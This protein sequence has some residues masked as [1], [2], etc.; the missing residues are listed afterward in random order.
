MSVP[1]RQRR[2]RPSLVVRVVQAI[3][4]VV[5]VGGPTAMIVGG[6]VGVA[7]SR[8]IDSSGVNTTAAVVDN[9]LHCNY[10]DVTY[11]T[12]VGTQEHGMVDTDGC[13]AV[14]SQVQVSYDPA[15]PNVVRLAFHSGSPSDEAWGGIVMG[16]VFILLEVSLL[17]RILLRA[18]GDSEIGREHGW[19]WRHR[20]VHGVVV[21]GVVFVMAEIATIFLL[22]GNRADLLGLVPAL[23]AVACLSYLCV[24]RMTTSKSK[25]FA[26]FAC[27][28]AAAVVPYL[29]T[30]V[31]IGVVG[32]PQGATVTQAQ[33]VCQ[34]SPPCVDTRY[35]SVQLEDGLQLPYGDMQ[36]DDIGVHRTG[37]RIKMLTDPTGF[38][39][40]RPDPGSVQIGT[41]ISMLVVALLVLLGLGLWP[42]LAG[43]LA[44]R[45]P[46][47]GNALPRA[48]RRR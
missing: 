1:T 43:P 38:V 7:H 6:V 39:A 46:A 4:L 13:L 25:G 12:G 34:G 16:A 8:Q 27:F 2:T 42:I 18:R 32:Q 37:D 14:G 15:A 33:E 30:N 45:F 11:R 5:I 17:V 44:Q 47:L 3:A 19:W 28:A 41:P 31:W 10:A 20:S 9:G 35:Y 29:A 21:A 22:F 36:E 24:P 26:W 40:P 48:P 23:L